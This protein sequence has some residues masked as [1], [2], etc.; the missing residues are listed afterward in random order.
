RSGVDVGH[1]Q[2]NRLVEQGDCVLL[3]LQVAQGHG[4]QPEDRH[5]RVGLA[6]RALRQFFLVSAGPPRQRQCGPRRSDLEKIATVH[7]EISPTEEETTEYKEGTE[8]KQT[9]FWFLFPCLPC[10]P[11]SPP[12]MVSDQMRNRSSRSSFPARSGRPSA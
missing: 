1:A 6:Q 10:I 9:R 4:A 12:S 3:T 11:W 8:K 7:H 2:V 5:L